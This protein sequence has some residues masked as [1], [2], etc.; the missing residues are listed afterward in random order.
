VFSSEDAGTMAVEG[1]ERTAEDGRDRGKGAE[2][3]GG[4]GGV[5]TERGSAA[6]GGRVA[7]TRGGTY[8]DF[9]IKIG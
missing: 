8:A 5:V 2:S 4:G 6:A 9:G 3:K 1:E 7:G